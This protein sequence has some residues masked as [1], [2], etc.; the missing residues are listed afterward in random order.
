MNSAQRGAV[1]LP[2]KF[3][4]L[5]LDEVRSLR[6]KLKPAVYDPINKILLVSD[7]KSAVVAVCVNSQTADACE[8]RHS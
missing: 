5:N 8:A 7:S 6:A 1:G 3:K 4:K 2:I